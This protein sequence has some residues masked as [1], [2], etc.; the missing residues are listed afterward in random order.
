MSRRA[1]SQ[2]ARETLKEGLRQAKKEDEEDGTGDISGLEVRLKSKSDPITWPRHVVLNYR[3]CCHGGHGYLF[4]DCCQDSE[5]EFVP[6]KKEK[7]RLLD[8]DSDDAGSSG[9]RS[10][11]KMRK[12][13][14]TPARRPGPKSRTKVVKSEDMT[15]LA[16]PQARET[17]TKKLQKWMNPNT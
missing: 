10:A 6:K 16:S 14:Q 11:K 1:A 4:F 8:S 13:P 15:P 5:D 17:I 3:G 2:K 7:K 12:S 9:R